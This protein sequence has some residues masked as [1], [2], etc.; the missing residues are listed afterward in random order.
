VN[1]LIRALNELIQVEVHLQLNIGLVSLT[2]F[3]HFIA[4]LDVLSK[5]A[6]VEGVQNL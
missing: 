2:H 6:R 3:P 4:P 5:E 1:G